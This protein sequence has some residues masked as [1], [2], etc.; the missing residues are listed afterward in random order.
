M[1]LELTSVKYK[2]NRKG[3]ILI[4]DK[5]EIKKRIGKSPDIMDAVALAFYNPSGFNADFDFA[6]V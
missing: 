2:F 5:D 4:E 1:T 3:E 6:I